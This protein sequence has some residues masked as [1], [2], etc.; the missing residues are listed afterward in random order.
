MT[1][2]SS[3]TKL[4]RKGTAQGS[5]LCPFLWNIAIDDCLNCNFPEKVKIGAFCDD[6]TLFT[7]GCY[8]ENM[9][10]D[11]QEACSTD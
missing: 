2:N 7:T 5:V 11:L 6:L 10:I 8:I 3:H 4:I 1:K 9:K